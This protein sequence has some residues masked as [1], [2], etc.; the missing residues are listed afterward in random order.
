LV[1]LVPRVKKETLDLQDLPTQDNSRRVLLALLVMV[2]KVLLVP[3]AIMATL[4]LVLKFIKTPAPI[5]MPNSTAQMFRRLLLVLQT[6]LTRRRLVL[7]EQLALVVV[8]IVYPVDGTIVTGFLLEPTWMHNSLRTLMHR[9]G[10][11]IV[12]PAQFECMRSVAQ[13]VILPLLPMAMAKVI[14]R[15]RVIKAK[16]VRK[17]KVKKRRR[18][19]KK[20]NEEITRALKG[21]LFF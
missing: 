7:S 10:K 15:S 2:N 12:V 5:L 6:P 4:P 13:L 20:L 1:F 9:G 8:E 18:K 17:K 21:Q 11:E 3:Q 19:I 16:K 14:N